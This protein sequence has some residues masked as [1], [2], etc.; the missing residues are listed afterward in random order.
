MKEITAT[1]NLKNKLIKKI[2][3][4]NSRQLIH[5]SNFIDLQNITIE[6]EIER[7]PKCGN[8]IKRDYY[9]EYCCECWEPLIVKP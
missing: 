4:L 2:P 7:C 5:I 3:Y 1:E 9:D 8:C 6:E